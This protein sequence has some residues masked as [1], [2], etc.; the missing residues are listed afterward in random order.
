MGSYFEMF[1]QK[2]IIQKSKLDNIKSIYI[3]KQLIKYISKKKLLKLVKMNK[4]NQKN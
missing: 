3:L 4:W 2:E 1:I